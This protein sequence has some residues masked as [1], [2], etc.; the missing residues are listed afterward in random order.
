MSKT[1]VKTW[2]KEAVT[3]L[4]SSEINSAQLDAE[5]ILCDA[6][7]VSRE[8]LIIHGSD[9]IDENI[10][11]DMLQRRMKR[12]PLAYIRGYKE[13]YGKNFTVNKNVLIPRPESEIIIDILKKNAK[14]KQVILDVGTGSGALAIT[15]SLELPFT[16]VLASDIS[17][18][19]LKIAKENAK[20]L[21]ANITFIESNLLFNINEQCDIILAN[22]PYVD[23]SWTRSDETNFEPSLALFA[24]DKG[25]DLIKRLTIQAQD[26]LFKDGLLLLEADPRQHKEIIDFSKDYGFSLFKE[27]DY[28]IALKN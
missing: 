11:K 1:K 9:E 26:T 3:L 16:R 7:N 17:K 15:A 5:L 14:K 10:G 12:E 28:I 20:R 19:A 23:E 13:F 4:K 21:N 27:Q 22:L 25:L 8:W 2:L 24:K 6:L 18:E